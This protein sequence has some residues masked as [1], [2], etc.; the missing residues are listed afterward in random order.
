[1]SEQ[2][3]E[4]FIDTLCKVA[5]GYSGLTTLREQIANVVDPVILEKNQQQMQLGG[6]RLDIARLRQCVTTLT[7]AAGAGEQWLP[8][9]IAPR[10]IEIWA[11]NGEQARMKWSEGPEWALW[12]WADPV[13]SDIDP[14]PDQPTFWRPIPADPGAQPVGRAREATD[15][16]LDILSEVLGAKE[17]M[18][19]AGCTQAAFGAMF[20]EFCGKRGDAPPVSP[21]AAAACSA[22]ILRDLERNDWTPEEALRWYAAGKHF[23]VSNGRTRIVDTGAV[24]SI[25]LKRTNVAH[26]AEKGRDASFPAPAGAATSGAPKVT[27]APAAVK[28]PSLSTELYEFYP[29]MSAQSHAEAVKDYARDVLRRA[30]V[31]IESPIEETR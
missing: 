18:L 9:G 30:R 19:T 27:K 11:F 24:A 12:V 3:I 13:L 8:I 23:D 28:L 5:A 29:S 10:E 6:A 21:D 14:S 31:K 25:A 20:A 26:H 2:E 17:V 22:D 15:D 16:A 4:I 7:A 1:M